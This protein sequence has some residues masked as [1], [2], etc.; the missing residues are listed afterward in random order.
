[1]TV[2][3]Q[4]DY[5]PQSDDMPMSHARI[6]HAGNWL[7]DGSTFGSA[8][9]P[10]SRVVSAK[11]TLTYERWQPSSMPGW[12]EYSHSG[13]AECDNCC[14]A[15]HT[16][17][18]N[19]NSLRVQYYNGSAWIDLIA[20]TPIEDDSP[21]MV[22]FQPQTRSRWRIY[23]SGGT[24]PEIRVVKFG[25]ALQLG[26]PIY[27]GHTP[28]PL[29]RQTMLRSNYSETG[30]YLGRTV[31]R[32][33]QSSSFS[34]RHLSSYWVRANWPTLQRA[35]EAEPFFIAW[36]PVKFGDVGFCQ[37]DEVPVATNMGIADLMEASMTVRARG[38]D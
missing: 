27:G 32:T 13:A 7:D 37:V 2:L 1:M 33:Y 8:T 20:N 21:I 30:E 15:A 29:A 10:D 5:A 6:A 11:N 35:I 3:F 23:V 19:G 31:Q 38:Y 24:V 34:W 14:I 36:R 9:N 4:Q 26:R 16:M 12:W 28:L 18:S 17:G 25:K 22:F